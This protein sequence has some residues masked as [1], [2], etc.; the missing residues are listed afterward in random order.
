MGSFINLKYLRQ[1]VRKDEK[2]TFILYRYF[3]KE[4]NQSQS[5]CE[6][7]WFS[8]IGILKEKKNNMNLL[9]CTFF[10]LAK[11]FLVSSVS[12]SSVTDSDS[13]AWM[14]NVHH[15]NCRHGKHSAPAELVRC[16]QH[17][18]P[19]QQ[20]GLLDSLEIS[21]KANHLISIKVFKHTQCSSIF[22]FV[23][24]TA[25]LFIRFSLLFGSS[26]LFSA[27][28]RVNVSWLSVSWCVLNWN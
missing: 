11:N 7:L 5:F 9:R 27:A 13:A 10:G 16:L 25:F 4:I 8:W 15:W 3:S 21:Y 28:N 22:F 6:Q 18:I 19:N 20:E 24:Q 23:V 17:R 26:R 1:T 2:S 12:F 14:L